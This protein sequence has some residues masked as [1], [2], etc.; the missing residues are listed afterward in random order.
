MCSAL[1]S[2]E[3]GLKKDLDPSHLSI[4]DQAMVDNAGDM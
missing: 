4:L 3:M 1:I 2:I